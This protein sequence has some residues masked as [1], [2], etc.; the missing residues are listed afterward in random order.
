MKPLLRLACLAALLP[1]PVL[2][3]E[4]TTVDVYRELVRHRTAT[5]GVDKA[6]ARG[7]RSYVSSFLENPDSQ[8]S[9][10]RDDPPITNEVWWYDFVDSLPIDAANKSQAAL[11]MLQWQGGFTKARIG[12]DVVVDDAS[13]VTFRN[14][15]VAA[16]AIK[17]GV[18]ADIFWK[19][20]DLN[21]AMS[22]LAAG[23]AVALQLL[24]DQVRSHA[25]ETHEARGIKAEVLAR[26]LKETNPERLTESD[27]TYLADLLRF[28]LSDNA[29]TIDAKGR[30]QL[31]AAYRV[32]RVAA[33]Y[34]DSAGYFSPGGYCLGNDPR[35]G[36]P[37]G[38]DAA[39]YNIPLCF[40][41]ATDRAVQSWFRRKMRQEEASV[42]RAHHRP[43]ES[44]RLVHFWFNAVLTLIDVAGFIEFAEA[45]LVSELS[46]EG[47]VTEEEAAVVDE[48]ATQLSCRIRP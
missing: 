3:A 38:S 46:T 45:G 7:T 9:A 26:Y 36:S 44:D 42:H 11:E 34:A 41:A 16:N 39:E 47:V 29:F 12:V 24:R 37:Q 2:A 14:G 6:F 43:D 17:A 5:L 33:A 27:L 19:A 28:A 32:A 18:D 4:P 22:T 23:Q 31:P 25:P 1:L 30:R 35:P 40:V 10:L 21:G 20:R 48:R 8:Y 15:Y 13:F